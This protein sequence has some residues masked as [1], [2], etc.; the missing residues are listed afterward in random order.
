MPPSNAQKFNT[1]AA[2][3]RIGV[4]K[5]TLLRWFKQGKIEDVGRDRN[6]WRV[7]SAADIGR[8]KKQMGMT[9]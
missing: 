4:S 2:A 6:G 5:A 9:V 8:I 1:A 7:F 3:R